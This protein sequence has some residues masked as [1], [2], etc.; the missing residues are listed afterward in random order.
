MAG[1][2]SLVSAVRLNMMEEER[3]DDRFR[4]NAGRFWGAVGSLIVVNVG[5]VVG[6]A[7]WRR[8]L[9]EGRRGEQRELARLY[10]RRTEILRFSKQ[11][12]RGLR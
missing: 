4:G 6:G 10:E 11:Q 7:L 12:C 8:S 9:L 2:L 5:L 1:G 3:G